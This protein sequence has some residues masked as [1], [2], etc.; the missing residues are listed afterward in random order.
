MSSVVI[1]HSHITEVPASPTNATAPTSNSSSA[2]PGQG[3]HVVIAPTTTRVP[4]SLT[5][6]ETPVHGHTLFALPNSEAQLP[7]ADDTPGTGT[8]GHG[9]RRFVFPPLGSDAA[10]TP[11]QPRPSARVARRSS[12]FNAADEAHNEDGEEDARDPT[13]GHPLFDITHN[14]ALPPTMDAEEPASAD[15]GGR[16]DQPEPVRGQDDGP[17]GEADASRPL[18]GA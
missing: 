5:T 6:L 7:S 4:S 9:T 17:S 18:G 2:S 14:A 12:L 13:I 11:V 10:S 1:G 3:L 8:H 15:V 16:F